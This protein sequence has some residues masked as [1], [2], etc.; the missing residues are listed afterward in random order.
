MHRTVNATIVNEEY[1]KR[2]RERE[3]R[4]KRE[5][6]AG[7]GTARTARSTTGR[8]TKVVASRRTERNTES[9]GLQTS[10]EPDEG[11]GGWKP[12]I[13]SLSPVG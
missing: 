4:E 1:R 13:D 3:K 12:K 6:E 8:R 10:A 7:R 11:R 5:K 2:E 9:V